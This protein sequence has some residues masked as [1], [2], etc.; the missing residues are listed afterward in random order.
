MGKKKKLKKALKAKKQ[1][2]NKIFMG[3]FIITAYFTWLFTLQ[4]IAYADLAICE[5]RGT[6]AFY[7][8]QGPVGFVLDISKKNWK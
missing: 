2:K 8:S 6:E 1:L 4:A 5:A 7:E 3:I